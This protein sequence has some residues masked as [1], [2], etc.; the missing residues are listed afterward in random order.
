MHGAVLG[1][2]DIPGR[3]AHLCYFGFF[4]QRDGIGFVIRG[5]RG[6]VLSWLQKA[7]VIPGDGVLLGCFRQRLLNVVQRQVSPRPF[8]LSQVKVLFHAFV[9]NFVVLV[10]GVIE[11]VASCRVPTLRLVRYRSFFVALVMVGTWCL[12]ILS[13][14]HEV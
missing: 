1:E 4:F 12:L 13:N 6:G 10:V 5:T 7:P 3:L 14:G 8:R 9:T 2:G 11:P